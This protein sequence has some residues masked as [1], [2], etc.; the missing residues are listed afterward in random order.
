MTTN[1]RTSVIVALGAAVAVVLS[2]VMLTLGRGGPA[3]SSPA[4]GEA[5]LVVHA[6]HATYGGLND[7]AG[8]ASAI[9]AG[10]VTGSA[11]GSPISGASGDPSAA[12]AIPQTDFAIR[13][14][15]VFKGSLAAGRAVTVTVTGGAS[16]AGM[17]EQEGVP[18]LIAGQQ[19]V[20]FLTAGDDTKFY[21]LAGGA[22]IA[23][24]TAD[25]T[26][27]L[28]AEAGVNGAVLA[29]TTDQLA[30]VPAPDRVLVMLTSAPL[31]RTEGDVQSGSVSISYAS[32]SPTGMSGTALIDGRLVSLAIT[33]NGRS[34]TG[35]LTLDDVTYTLQ[36]R[37]VVVPANDRSVAVNGA[38]KGPAGV[39][40][41][42]LQVFDR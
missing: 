17:V 34:A 11:A 26:F 7:L 40:Q 6:D 16:G 41:L 39:Q 9:L 37:A 21:P 25:G 18:A 10:T 36:P 20:F 42:R 32:G 14:D 38:V 28:P 22:A 29:F 30:T 5:A 19:Y 27:A 4:P 1:R 13:I 8:G 12:D 24:R 33:I 23:S 2:V 3:T 31:D 35:S 15:R